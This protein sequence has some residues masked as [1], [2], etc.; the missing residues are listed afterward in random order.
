MMSEW[1]KCSDRM[2]NDDSYVVAAKHYGH[3]ITPDCFVA[4]FYIGNF[5]V[6]TDGIEASNYDGGAC[7][8]STITPTHWLALP[9]INTSDDSQ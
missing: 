7:I 6:F 1:I 5:H 2:P 8:T 9:E 3:G 4:W